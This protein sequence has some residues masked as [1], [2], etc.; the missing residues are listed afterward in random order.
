MT[1]R[2]PS[3]PPQLRHRLGC[4][5]DPYS[6]C[7]G[8]TGE[9]QLLAD[10]FAEVQGLED[11]DGNGFD[12]LSWECHQ[13]PEPKGKRVLDDLV[14][15]LINVAVTWPVNDLLKVRREG[16]HEVACVRQTTRAK[17]LAPL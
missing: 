5:P 13:F 6:E 16:P 2:P 12:L 4:S 7:R 3:P 1:P 8:F 15:A 14:F 9:C 17:L 11:A 10:T